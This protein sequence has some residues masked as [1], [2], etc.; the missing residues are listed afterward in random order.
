MW[1]SFF[2]TSMKANIRLSAAARAMICKLFPLSRLPLDKNLWITIKIF[3]VRNRINIS[4]EIELVFEMQTMI[5]K[6]SK[7]TVLECI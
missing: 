4:V 3:T 1:I 5:S 2:G 7:M 6:I